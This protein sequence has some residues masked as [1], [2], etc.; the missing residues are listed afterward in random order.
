M[1][2]D[3]LPPPA[4]PSP[5]PTPK[6]DEEPP[7]KKVE[8]G[9]VEKAGR[10]LLENVVVPVGT[11]V[12]K[13]TGAPTRAA[14]AAIQDGA[15]PISAF[16]DQF[17]EN[18]ELAPTGKEIAQKA[19][20]SD[21]SLSD[22]LPSLYSETGDEW[23]KFQRGGLLD[24][25]ASGAAGLG[26]DIAADWTNL[27]PGAVVA[28]GAAQ[29]GK[30]TAKAGLK[31]AGTAGNLGAKALD[32]ATGTEIASKAAKATGALADVP[33]K[34]V[35]ALQ[36]VVSPKQSD[37]FGKASEVA[38]KIGIEPEGLPASIEFGPSS[39]AS[40]LE[41]S[42]REGP[43][44]EGLLKSYGD[45]RGKV[46]SAAEE[47]IKKAAGGV[48]L[49]DIHAGEAISTGFKDAQR[50]LFQDA[51]LRYKSVAEY[52]PGVRVNKD[53]AAK[54]DK[55]LEGVR[56]RAIGLAKRG[57]TGDQSAQ[58]K[59]L[60]VTVERLQNV[61]KGSYKQAAEQLEMLGNAAFGK[62]KP[63]LGK[64]QVD[65]K[66]LAKLYHELSDALLDTVRKDINPEFADEIVSNNAKMSSFFKNR[67]QVIKVL[68]D[69][70]VAPET[71]FKRLVQGA[72]SKQIEAL[73]NT[74]TPEQFNSVRGSYLN[75]LVRRNSD[76]EIMFGST[77]N[78]LRKEK[79]R[80]SAFFSPKEISELEDILELGDNFGPE[81]LSTSGTGGS[82][83]FRGLVDG[84]TNGLINE[85]AL[86]AIK[87]R[88]RGRG[89][90]SAPGASR[91]GEVAEEVATELPSAK[92]SRG[93]LKRGPV[94]RRL[95]AAQSVAPSN[96]N[97]RKSR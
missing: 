5:S 89:L 28:K 46:V 72:D 66:E 84:V 41:R 36:S 30:G 8:P 43:A 78:A 75:N 39:V 7:P 79:S 65:Q 81:V 50:K 86:N 76:G 16:T 59:A 54:F 27:I 62:S 24:P 13:Y 40:R 42:V 82:N 67:D 97:E 80:L 64:A 83:A 92:Q 77:R 52:A 93:L 6:W 33:G 85:K 96:Y 38:K 10:G 68:D 35:D 61:A 95:K 58:G 1:A 94:E 53:A 4:K 49:S 11:F 69:P 29:A 14:V 55:A 73:K 17:G 9:L 26:V 3:D 44:G 23:T 25:T 88:G 57:V 20:V 60:L 37:Y 91:V 21:T 2:W 51:E 31:A 90:L 48:P 70:N 56:R 47:G 19:G 12:D 63:V 18:P 87:D 15:N 22:V 71:V 32:V 45:A 34:A 74:L